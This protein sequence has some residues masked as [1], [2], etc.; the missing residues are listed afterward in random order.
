MAKELT[1]D[2]EN[3]KRCAYPYTSFQKSLQAGNAVAEM[4]G[5]R[6]EVQKSVLAHHLNMD[7]SGAAFS[8]TVGSAKCF[9]IIEGRGAYRLTDLGRQYFRPTAEGDKRRALLMMLTNPEVY[10]RLITR[11]DGSKLPPGDMLTNLIGS[12][13]GVS[14]SWAPRVASMFLS[15]IRHSGALDTSGFVRYAA[16]MHARQGST[17]PIPAAGP[18]LTALGD[19]TASSTRSQRPVAEQPAER[20]ESSP[21]AADTNVWHF[22]LGDGTVKLETS[23]ELSVELW[24]KLNQYVEVLKPPTPSKETP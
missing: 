7:E 4:G 10:D 24:R 18:E 21:A 6:T 15:A 11:F 8:Q 1:A 19:L 23:R 20:N 16:T 13:L 14:K 9:G 22:R 5:D 12:D 17:M 3:G 2:A